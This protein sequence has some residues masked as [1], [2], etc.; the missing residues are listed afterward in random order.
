ML[1]MSLQLA[2]NGG[3]RVDAKSARPAYLRRAVDF[4][5]AHLSQ[6]LSINDIAAVAG[7]HPRTLHKVFC[8]HF[9][10]SVMAFIQHQRLERVQRRLVEADPQSMSVTDAA[11]ENGF[12]HL[13]RFAAAYRCRFGEYPSE[14][15]RR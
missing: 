9:G 3:L 8:Q 4:I 1:L 12:V 5:M 14:T 13:S 15:L 7:V 6:P 2:A 10:E 11:V